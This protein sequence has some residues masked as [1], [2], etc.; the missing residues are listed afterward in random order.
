MTRLFSNSEYVDIVLVYGEVFGSAPRVRRITVR[1]LLLG[2]HE[3]S[4]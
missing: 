1:F 4:V 3:G 2:V